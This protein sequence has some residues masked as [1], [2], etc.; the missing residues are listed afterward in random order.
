MN[1]TPELSEMTKAVHGKLLEWEQ[2]VENSKKPVHS[3]ITIIGYKKTIALLQYNAALKIARLGTELLERSIKNRSESLLLGL[4]KRPMFESYTRGMWFEYI[5]EEKQA[6]GFL[7]RREEDAEEGW[8]TLR[9]EESAPWLVQMWDVLEEKKIMEKTV[10]WMRKQREW[11]ND[12]A[13]VTAR[14]VQIGWSNKDGKVLQSDESMIRD[15]IALVEIGGQCAG[16]MHVLNES[17]SAK[18]DRINQEKLE[19]RSILETYL[20][21][22]FG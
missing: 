5:A 22:K 13:H 20:K 19:F 16:H 21:S 18:E 8:T 15:L 6:K 11:W 14:S 3:L 7:K 10:E 12:S 4:I 2:E 17:D 9:S 1:G